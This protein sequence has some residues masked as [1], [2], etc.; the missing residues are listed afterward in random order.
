VDQKGISGRAHS[1]R[2]DFH[3]VPRGSAQRL[4][5]ANTLIASSN[6]GIALGVA[7]EGGIVWDREVTRGMRS[8]VLSEVR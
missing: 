6:S 7:R 5:N 3:S 1:N 8:G 2:Q 4:P